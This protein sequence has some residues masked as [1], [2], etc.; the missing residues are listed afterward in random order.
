MST[1]SNSV[2]KGGDLRPVGSEETARAL[3]EG[4]TG[5]PVSEAEWEH[6]RA[7]LLEFATILRAWDR[8]SRAKTELGNV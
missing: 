3:I 4:R 6:G 2:R 8:E 1:R 5:H 7:R